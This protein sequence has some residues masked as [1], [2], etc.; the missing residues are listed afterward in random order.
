MNKLLLIGKNGQVGTELKQILANY[1]DLISLDRSQ[2]DLAKPE[3]IPQII[4][5]IKPNM[6]IN[7]AAYTAVDQAE[8]QPEL[9][10]QINAIAPQILAEECAKIGANLIHISTDYVFDGYKNTPYLEEDITNP[11]SV[12]G[13]TKLAGE[14]AIK[15]TNVN[16]II[17]RTA[18]VYGTYGKGNFVKTMLRLGAQRELLKVVIDQVGC[19]TY[20]YDI[21]KAIA[22]LID[23]FKGEKK[24]QETYHFTNSGVISWYDF[25]V[26]I[27]EEAHK[28]GYGLKVKEIIPITTSEYPTPA[29]RPAYSVLSNKKI[30]NKL[31]YYP[32]YWRNSL[33]KMLQTLKL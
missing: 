7:A 27:F 24:F 26:T 17:L 22:D 11:L 18:W 10:Y 14:E 29:M 2:I 12:Y 13:Q 16:Y 23:T 1:G 30:S 33:C 15:K 3:L 9:A 6:V 31:G 5:Q 19:P 4:K 8:S 20:A 28:L 25:A 32:P 21:A